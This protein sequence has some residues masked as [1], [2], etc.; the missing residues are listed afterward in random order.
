[1]LERAGV[2]VERGVLEREALLV[3]G[4]WRHSLR[5]G[6]PYITV[7]YGARAVSE[8]R[9]THDLVIRRNG[10]IEEGAPGGHGEGAFR[11]PHQPVGDEP[12]TVLRALA[13]AG[14]RT[15]LIDGASNDAAR[16]LADAVDRVITK[17][18]RRAASVLAAAALPVGAVPVV[19]PPLLLMNVAV[20]AVRRPASG[21]RDGLPAFDLGQL[22]GERAV[23][24]FITE[25]A[26]V[27]LAR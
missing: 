27:A 6:R 22:R 18:D 7:A 9:R 10:T 19:G 23:D 20:F 8:L 11:V 3:L 25:V 15:V 1:M 21:S 17:A 4:P 12:E 2:E 24:V 13:E 14:A 26:A 16:L 5:T